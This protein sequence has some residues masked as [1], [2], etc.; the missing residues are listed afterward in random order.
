MSVLEALPCPVNQGPHLFTPKIPRATTTET[1]ACLSPCLSCVLPFEVSPAQIWKEYDF[2]TF[3]GPNKAIAVG[4]SGEA[5]LSLNN[6]DVMVYHGAG[7]L[8]T[9][10]FN[11]T[12][13]SC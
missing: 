7:N 1:K 12:N 5:E 10:V 9:A 13:N 6:F 3:F 11:H 2:F 8:H 4:P